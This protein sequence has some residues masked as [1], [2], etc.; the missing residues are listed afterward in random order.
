M[1]VKVIAEAGINHNGNMDL[2]KKLIDVAADSGADL[3]KFQTYAVDRLL[4]KSAKK[5]DYQTINDSADSQYE[6]L[7]PMELSIEMHKELIRYC[8]KRKIGFLSSGFDCQSVD[9]LVELGVEQLKIPSG[10]ITNL[11]YLR[12]IAEKQK[13]VILS[14]GMSCLEEVKAA[15]DVLECGINKNN[16]ALLHCNTEYPTPYEDVNLNAIDTL[17]KELNVEV[18]YSDHTLGVEVAIA[19]VALGATIIEKHITL[20]KNMQG[21]DHKASL[22]PDE[23]KCMISAI[24]NIEKAMGCGEKTPSQ[25]ES[26]NIPI[27]RKSLIALSDIK[28]GEVLSHNNIVAKRPGNGISPML[29][30]TVIGTKA[31]REFNADEAIEIK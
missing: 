21:P 30:D 25:S 11:P 13:P 17:R 28:K 26:K 15:V 29:W 16:I 4:T 10:E 7:R 18:G 22:E 9:L 31:I 8:N 20:D 5:A 6:M 27:A 24:R 2:A 3:V 12:N 19:A 1:K 14:T 23:L